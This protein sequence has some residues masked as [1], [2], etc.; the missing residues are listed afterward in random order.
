MGRRDLVVQI[1]CDGSRDAGESSEGSEVGGCVHERIN[2]N[3]SWLAPSSMYGILFV[4]ISLIV[5]VERACIARY[6]CFSVC[7]PSHAS[8]EHSDSRGDP[9]SHVFWLDLYV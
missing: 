8:I 4:A 5:A 7:L 6:R 1:D 2:Q 9:C 3:S